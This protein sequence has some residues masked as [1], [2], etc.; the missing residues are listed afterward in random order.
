LK[1]EIANLIETVKDQTKQIQK[2]ATQLDSTKA[3]ERIVAN[4]R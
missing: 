4:N 2:V 3:A 1:S